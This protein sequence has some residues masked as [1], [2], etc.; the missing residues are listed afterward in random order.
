MKL[1]FGKTADALS[2]AASA[3]K[4]KLQDGH[5]EISAAYEDA[6]RKAEPYREDAEKMLEAIKSY[7]VD[8]FWVGEF[9]VNWEDG[10][11]HEWTGGD[12]PIRADALIKAERL[13]GAPTIDLASDFHWEKDA[14]EMV[15]AFRVL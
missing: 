4:A 1:F 9:E 5:D 13:S 3:P 6:M 7:E 11:W 12:C 2:V 15:V 8:L 14:P 10:D